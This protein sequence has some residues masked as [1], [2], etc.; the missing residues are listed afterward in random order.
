VSTAGGD[1]IIT[2]AAGDGFDAVTGGAGSDVIVA[3]ANN[4][5]IGLR[6]ISTIE[7]IDA[8]GHTGV[9]IVGSALNDVLN[10]R[11]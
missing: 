5:N 4:I 8:N 2:V 1:D 10:F 3:M 7:D 11:P 6:S 9:R